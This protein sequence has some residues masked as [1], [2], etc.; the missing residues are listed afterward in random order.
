MSAAPPARLLRLARIA[1]VGYALLAASLYALGSVTY[2]GELATVCLAPRDE[3]HSRELLTPDDLPHLAADGLSPRAWAVAQTT[4]RTFITLIFC[5]IGLLI[6]AR[7]HHEGTGLLFSFC[8]LGTG[9]IGGAY[10]SLRATYPSLAPLVQLVR[11][12]TF[13]ALALLY[14]TFPTGR[15]VPAAMWLPLGLWSL[16]LFLGQF[17]NWPPPEHPVYGIMAPVAW[18]GLLGSGALAQVYRYRRHSSPLERRQTKWVLFAIV[19]VSMVAVFGYFTPMRA[20]MNVS[21]TYSMGHLV[22]LIGTNLLVA[23]IPISVGIAILRH[24]LFDIDVIIRRTLVYSVLTALLAL[25]YFGTI[26]LLQALFGSLTGNIQTP[27]VTVLSTLTMAALFGPLRTR[28]QRVIDRRLFRRKY[29]AARTLTGFAA[30][31][32][33]ETDLARLSA[34]LVAVVDET[35][36]PESVGLWLTAAGPNEARHRYPEIKQVVRIVGS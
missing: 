19:L 1:L 15:V 35:M 16:V 4:Y 34:R 11:Y 9:L 12:P 7:K 17:A 5:L 32:R 10:E 24:N 23:L 8:L 31:A 36:Q 26:V 18:L 27:L 33:D 14:A 25:A 13:I 28:V 21:S 6:F 2:F 30:G 29:D 20:L 3:C 22:A